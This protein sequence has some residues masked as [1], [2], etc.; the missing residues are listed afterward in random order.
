MPS[1]FDFVV[2]GAGMAGASIAAELSRNARVAIVERESQPG[3]HTT[4]RSAALYSEIYG[5]ETIRALTRASRH[6]FFHPPT[7]FC[8]HPLVAKRGTLFFARHSETDL[9]DAYAQSLAADI[10][11]IR[12]DGSH[13]TRLVPV[14]RP[15]YLGGGL[16]EDGSADIDVAALLQGYL[17]QPSKTALSCCKT[18]KS[19]R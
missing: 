11:P 3:Y 13:A 15:G 1:E 6:F 17:V 8:A 2:I 9:L 16:Y 12:I 5:N 4:G 14:F 7:G 18:E 10:R 19:S